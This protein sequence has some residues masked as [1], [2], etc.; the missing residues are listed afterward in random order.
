MKVN[1]LPLPTSSMLAP[2]PYSKRIRPGRFSCMVPI[3][4]RFLL[5]VWT[6]LAVIDCDAARC[7]ST[8]ASSPVEAA[9]AGAAS[10]IPAA[11]GA[12]AGAKRVGNVICSNLLEFFVD[13]WRSGLECG[14]NPSVPRCSGL[15]RDSDRMAVG[16]DQ[17]LPAAELGG[18]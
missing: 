15:Q 1:V 2:R 6:K 11:A 14:L 13:T 9:M 5:S 12:R 17:N 3:S 8:K 10:K 4:W 18:L 16:V 7:A